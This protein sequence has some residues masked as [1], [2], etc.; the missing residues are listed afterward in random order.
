MLNINLF[1]LTFEKFGNQSKIFD[2]VDLKTI[3]ILD[4]CITCMS[5]D[6]DFSY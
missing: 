5:D 2:F 3:V 6:P 1:M 4:M